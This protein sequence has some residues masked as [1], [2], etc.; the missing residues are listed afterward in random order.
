MHFI[1]PRMVG[2]RRHENTVLSEGISIKN[3]PECSVNYQRIL[4]DKQQHG[5]RITVAHQDRQ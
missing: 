1:S 5:Y 2:G 3:R 4:H